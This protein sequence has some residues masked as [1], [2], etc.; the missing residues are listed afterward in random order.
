M[1]LVGVGVG[2]MVQ[3][4]KVPMQDEYEEDIECDMHLDKRI[5]KLGELNELAYEDHY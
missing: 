3:I 2:S 4:N 5:V 1:L